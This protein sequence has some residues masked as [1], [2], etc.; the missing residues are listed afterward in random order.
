MPKLQKIFQKKSFTCG[1]LSFL[2]PILWLFLWHLRAPYS[3][4]P[5]V[6]AQRA[7]PLVQPFRWFQSSWRP[8]Q[9]H[10]IITSYLLLPPQ[11][12]GFQQTLT[13]QQAEEASLHL[14]A[15]SCL[16]Q[17]MDT[18]CA[19]EAHYSPPAQCN[20]QHAPQAPLPSNPEP[21]VAHLSPFLPVP[22]LVMPLALM[23]AAKMKEFLTKKSGK[24]GAN[25]STEHAD[26]NSVKLKIPVFCIVL[27]ILYCI[28]S[29]FLYHE[30]STF[31]LR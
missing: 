4:A 9:L 31:S 8:N 24:D 21:Q 23:T 18:N 20:A 6:A 29:Q 15:W 2:A 13:H 14:S 17:W 12:Y 16:A 28:N 25:R 3:F 11:F 5:W 19:L 22:L 27:C 26:E 1:I 30:C 7:H 10:K